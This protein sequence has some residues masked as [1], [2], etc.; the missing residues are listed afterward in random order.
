MRY[1]LLLRGINVGGKNK[2]VMADLKADLEEL[3]FENA[4]SYINSGNLFFNS[5]EGE[6]R[7][8]EKLE[9]YFAQTYD[10]PL[11]FVLLSS[12]ILQEEAKRLP[13]WWWDE[14]AYRRDVLFYLPEA[15]REQIMAETETWSNDKEQIHF[16]Q[17]AF[18]YSNADQADYL[19]S[20]YH[21]KL[22]KS[23]F[24]KKVTIR[25]GKTFQKILELV[26]KD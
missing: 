2:V 4:V 7:I 22:L 13:A 26:G 20:N 17:T 15:D 1:I 8:R 25:N 16:G 18:F 19:K 23:S 5:E 21:K 10:F 12:A 3:G 6:E 9:S 11:P 24:Y 14:S